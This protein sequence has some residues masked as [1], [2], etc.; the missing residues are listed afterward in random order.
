MCSCHSRKKSGIGIVRGV[1]WCVAQSPQEGIKPLPLLWQGFPACSS[2]QAS[3]AYCGE[4]WNQLHTF[5]CICWGRHCCAF[6][7]EAR[8]L[9]LSWI[10]KCQPHSW[11]TDKVYLP[12]MMGNETC[13]TKQRATGVYAYAKKCSHNHKVFRD[14][15]LVSSGFS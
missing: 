1:R 15:P 2:W 4:S 6:W 13:V 12:Q 14:F 3:K 9:C 5:S 11:L 8:C 10:P 7:S